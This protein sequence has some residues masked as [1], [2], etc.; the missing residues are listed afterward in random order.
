MALPSGSAGSEHPGD[1]CVLVAE[2][3]ELVR[4]LAVHILRS[5]GFRVIAAKDG[6]EAVS[7]FGEH[8]KEIDVVLLDLTMPVLNGAEVLIELKRRRPQLPVVITSGYGG[9]S[10]PL[11]KAAMER[12]RFLQKPYRTQALLS[13]IRSMLPLGTA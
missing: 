12:T 11:P 10:S 9:P 1:P 5:N 6:A 4:D 8:E 3:E 13:E 2:D 7:L